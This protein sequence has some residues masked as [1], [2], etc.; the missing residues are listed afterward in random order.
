MWDFITDFGDSAVTLPLALLILTVLA[1]AREHR[2]ARDWA[3]TIAGCGAA[4]VA[5]KLVFGACG[6]RAGFPGILSPSGHTAISTAVYGGLAVLVGAALPRGRR[7]PLHLAAAFL[8]GG[9]AVSRLVLHRHDAA[10]IVAGLAVGIAAVALFAATLRSQKPVLPLAWL[11]LA[12]LA[13]VA[14]MH[15]TRWMVEPALHDA[16]GFLRLAVPWCG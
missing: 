15:G 16:A 7:L 6:S 8:I 11:A 12:G 13:S 4:I 9:I 1:M 14:L 3:L 10:E 2:L 5:L